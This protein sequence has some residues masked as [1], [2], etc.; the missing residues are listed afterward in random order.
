[1]TVTR[2][3]QNRSPVLLQPHAAYCRLLLRA[4]R[5]LMQQPENVYEGPAYRCARRPAPAV[6]ALRHALAGRGLKIAQNAELRRKFNDHKSGFPVGSLLTFA[7]FTSVSLDDRVA[8]GFGDHVLFTFTRVRG[9]RI[10]ALSAEPQEAEVLV[11][12]PS[13]FR[14]VAAAMFHG[15]LVV[16]LERVDSPLTYLALPPSP[17]APLPPPHPTPSPSASPAPSLSPAAASAR[18]LSAL[19]VPDVALIVRA[20]ARVRSAPPHHALR[21]SQPTARRLRAILLPSSAAA[22]GAA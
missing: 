8:N 22:S 12:P 18:S 21:R 19:S 17:A 6:A 1:L 4:T 13:V 3:S 16:T 14:I 5:C 10:R 11:P 15:S 2:C 9:V 20:A 7:A